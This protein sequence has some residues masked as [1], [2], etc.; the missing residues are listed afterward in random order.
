[1]E[2]PEIQLSHN[3]LDPQIGI[4]SP[5]VPMLFSDNFDWQTWS[6]FVKGVLDYEEVSI[7]LQNISQ[8]YVVFMD[9]FINYAN[10]VVKDFQTNVIPFVIM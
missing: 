10:A 5:E 9:F 7:T 1:M 2:H 8:I 6:G 3:L 4:C